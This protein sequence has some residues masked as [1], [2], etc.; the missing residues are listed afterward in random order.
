MAAAVSQMMPT[1]LLTQSAKV[2]HCHCDAWLSGCG[3][4]GWG[5]SSPSRHAVP[6]AV[7]HPHQ[8]VQAVGEESSLPLDS[9]CRH[10]ASIQVV[11]VRWG[12]RSCRSPASLPPRCRA[13]WLAV[14]GPALE[15]AAGLG[16]RR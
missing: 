12:R 16:R 2:S 3:D 8:V 11:A 5:G 1:A 7:E 14:G 9:S 4:V 13:G 10:V 15:R 6:L